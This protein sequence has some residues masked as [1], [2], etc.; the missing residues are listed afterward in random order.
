VDV[1][2]RAAA[3]RRPGRWWDRGLWACGL[4][5]AAIGVAIGG[6][7]LADQLRSQPESARVLSCQTELQ[8][9]GRWLGNRTTCE[10]T[11]GGRTVELETK[12]RHPS[13][14]TLSLRS[15]GDTVLDPALTHDRVWWLP[16]GVLIGGVTWWAGLPP[17]TDLTYG[18]HAAS[19]ERRR[20]TARR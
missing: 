20:G 13:G 4:A 18:R 15:T 8:A 17:R 10:V 9:Y 1:L 6:W 11:I 7:S 14:S 3:T 12:H 16:V 2:R 19:R 5:L